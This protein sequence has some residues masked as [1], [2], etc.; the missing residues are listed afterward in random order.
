MADLKISELAAASA[1]TGTELVE[2]VQG[3]VNKRTTTQ[4]IADLGAG[5]G[6]TVT[7]VSGTTDRITS[8]GGTTPVIDIAAAYDSAVTADIAAAQAAAEA[9]GVT[10]TV[11][12]QD[13]WVDAAAMIPRVTNGC[14]P[15][16]QTEMA[17]SLVNIMTL[18]FNQTTQQFAQFKITPPRKWN[19]GT[20][21]F[22]P[23]WTAAAGTGTVQWG[24]SLGSYRND[25]AL[26]IAL[27][28]PQTSDDTLIAV[29][30]LHIGPESSAITS[31]GTV[32]DGNLLVAQISRNPASDTLNAD[33][34]LIGI[35]I[36][37]TTDAA[38]DA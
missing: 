3:G 28:T 36:R 37:F 8:T 35:S 25:D 33:A 21:T 24:L 29:N 9:A 32:Q 18:D 34:K 2:L 7:S 27:G 22:V 13:L 4:E 20:V 5:G 14:S 15:L 23:H 16:A 11:G 31:S 10:A 6:G 19:N 30:D 17:T 26:T 12:I 38:K 1:L